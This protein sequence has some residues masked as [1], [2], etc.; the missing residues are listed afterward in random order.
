MKHLYLLFVL[1]FSFSASAQNTLLKEFFE[2]DAGV[3]ISEH[4]WTAHS[5]AGNNPIKTSENPLKFSGYIGENTGRAALVISNTSDENKPFS[6]SVEQPEEGQPSKHTYISFLVQ[7]YGPI[8]P[9]TGT[10]R[11]YFFHLAE[12]RDKQNPDFASVA[13][14]FRARVFMN[15]GSAEGTFRL[16]LSF[17]E[18]E[19]PADN[20]TQDLD[21]T[22]AYLVVLKY[23]SIAG[24]D[25][26]E[27]SLFV[28][29]EG[30]DFSVE[31][32]QPTIGPLKATGNDI[33]LQAVCL[34]QYMNE[35][36][37]MVDGILVRDNWDLAK[38]TSAD[39]IKIVTTKLSVYP[40][41][42]LKSDL[43]FVESDMDFPLTISIFN[44]NG[45]LITE[46]EIYDNAV[47]V[48]HL[49]AGTYILKAQNGQKT[50]L[51]KVVI[52]D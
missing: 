34:R 47:N 27:V 18:N 21:A 23:A 17:L 40:N 45:Q 26:D 49:S 52:V 13:T 2:Y 8:P 30:E 24:P 5:G 19:P 4:G 29:G 39:D 43:L 31:P 11:P 22:K 16:N 28:F 14:S 3:L 12:Y 44:L 1:L 36:N 20:L 6:A 46:Q 10:I 9:I 35:Q 25:N 37:V 38:P 50:A 41:P 51:E 33:T 48:S 32:S 7:P 15:P 42:N